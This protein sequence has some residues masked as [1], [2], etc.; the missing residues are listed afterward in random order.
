MLFTI[1]EL[2]IIK[3]APSSA[4]NALQENVREV[5]FISCILRLLLNSHFYVYPRPFPHCAIA[6]VQLFENESFVLKTYQMFSTTLRWRNLKTQQQPLILDLRITR[7]VKSHC[8]RDVIVFEKPRFQRLSRPNK[9]KKPA[10]SNSTGLKSV[11]EKLLLRDG[12]V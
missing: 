5:S 1:Q 10:L 4:F 3:K 8:Y 9:N 7:A 12:L 6:S 2:Y 11:F